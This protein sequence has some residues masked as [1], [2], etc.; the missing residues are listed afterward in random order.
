LISKERIKLDDVP[1]NIRP[2]LMKIENLFYCR[3]CNEIYRIIDEIPINIYPGRKPCDNPNHT[4]NIIAEIMIDGRVRKI[5]RCQEEQK[6]WI[7]RTPEK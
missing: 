6:I 2:F 1:E 7:E 3:F 5:F 4:I